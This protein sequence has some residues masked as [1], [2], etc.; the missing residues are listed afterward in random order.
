MTAA[1]GAVV[2]DTTALDADMALARA[3]DIVARA[4]AGSR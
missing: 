3:S 2:I 1:P 4:L